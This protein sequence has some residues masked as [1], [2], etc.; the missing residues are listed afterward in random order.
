[1]CLNLFSV[2][3]WL[4]LSTVQWKKNKI[5]HKIV[6]DTTVCEKMHQ[7]DSHLLTVSKNC[8]LFHDNQLYQVHDRILP[9]YIRFSFLNTFTVLHK[10]KLMYRNLWFWRTKFS[11]PLT[12][13]THSLHLS[14]QLWLSLPLPPH[15]HHCH[16][17]TNKAKTNRNLF[18]HFNRH[19][20]HFPSPEWCL[21]SEMFPL[22]SWVSV[23]AYGGI[24]AQITDSVAHLLSEST[25]FKTK[26]ACGHVQWYDNS[27][28]WETHF[29][30][31]NSFQHRGE[32]FMYNVWCYNT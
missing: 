25:V 29:K 1:M 5:A 14:L 6:F 4:L 32:A 16:I 27:M 8:A 13:E 2:T 9:F 23:R 17:A 11:F 3:F 24:R 30:E 19:L 12:P 18:S 10:Q 21:A 15:T 20:L 26:V 31:R 28:K 7:H 22:N